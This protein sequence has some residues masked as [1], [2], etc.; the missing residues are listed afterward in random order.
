MSLGQDNLSPQGLQSGAADGS[1]LSNSDSQEPNPPAATPHV[2]YR[3]AVC[4][5]QDYTLRYVAYPYVISLLVITFRRAFVGLW[6]RKHANLRL[7]SASLI[8]ACF[9]WLG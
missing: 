8:S 7:I 2:D 9:G 4:G 5:R 6:C 1:Q 3:C